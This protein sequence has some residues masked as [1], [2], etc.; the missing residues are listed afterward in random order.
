M[1]LEGSQKW[2]MKDDARTNLYP[3]EKVSVGKEENSKD[4]PSEKKLQPE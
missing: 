4:R 3:I 1:R 2:V